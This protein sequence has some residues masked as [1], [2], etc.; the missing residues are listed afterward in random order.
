MLI[1]LNKLRIS[2]SKYPST[3][4]S[5]FNIFC[6]KFQHLKLEYLLTKLTYSDI[7]SH[8]KS[9][10]PSTFPP[11]AKESVAETVRSLANPILKGGVLLEKIIGPRSTGHLELINTTLYCADSQTSKATIT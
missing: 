5:S 10:Q 7:C 3:P 1:S 8:L 2:F 11:E 9:G 4:K 6:Q